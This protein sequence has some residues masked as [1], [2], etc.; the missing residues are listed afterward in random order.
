LILDSI[1]RSDTYPTV[2]VHNPNCQVEHEASVTALR[3]DQL[4]YC[5]SRGI[6]EQ[7]AQALVVNGFIEPFVAMLP[8]EY[9]VEIN[10]LIALE[11]EGSIG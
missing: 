11:M 10:R 6:S 4:T 8:M 7:N 1:S 5:M 3:E 9:A 2:D